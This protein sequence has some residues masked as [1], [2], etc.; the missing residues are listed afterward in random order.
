LNICK[1][2][3]TIDKVVV[4]KDVKLT[5]S[6]YKSELQ[7]DLLKSYIEKNIDFVL[8]SDQTLIVTDTEEEAAAKQAALLADTEI[9][10]KKFVETAKAVAKK[11]IDMELHPPD[12]E[13]EDE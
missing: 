4:G 2:T 6:C 11:R 13:V 7:V 10:R 12:S 9:T 3:G 5:I 8:S 1:F